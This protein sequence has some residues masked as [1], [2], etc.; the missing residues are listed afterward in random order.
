MRRRLSKWLAGTLAFA[1]LALNLMAFLHASAMMRFTRISQ[2]E[3]T[4]EP[5]TLSLVQK[6]KVLATGVRGCLKT[7]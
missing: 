4:H 3:R 1:F 5:E 2:V 6:V 7:L